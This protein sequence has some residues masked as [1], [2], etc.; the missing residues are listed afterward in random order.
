M[1]SR[2]LMSDLSMFL[3]LKL[4]T[5]L[6]SQLAQLIYN[7]ARFFFKLACADFYFVSRGPG[8]P[9]D[10]ALSKSSASFK[11]RYRRFSFFYVSSV[12]TIQGWSSGSR[13]RPQQFSETEFDEFDPISVGS[14]DALARYFLACIDFCFVS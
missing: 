10:S 5:I 14:V 9:S 8:F 6:Q 7:L 3:S 11:I 12:I 2:D 13:L 4:R 1:I